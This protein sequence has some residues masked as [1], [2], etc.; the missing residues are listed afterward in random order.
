[1][2][3]SKQYIEALGATAA[4]GLVDDVDLLVSA[5]TD[6]FFAKVPPNFLSSKRGCYAASFRLY[7]WKSSIQYNSCSDQTK[8]NYYQAD[9]LPLKHVYFVS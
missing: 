2:R 7:Q 5:F 4:V 9:R 1:M 8:A 3:K 6:A